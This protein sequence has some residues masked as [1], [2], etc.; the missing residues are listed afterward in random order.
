MFLDFKHRHGS[1]PRQDLDKPALLIGTKMRH[2]NEGHP[3]VRRQVAEQ[4]DIGFHTA[5]RSTDSHHRKR[6]QVFRVGFGIPRG[7]IFRIRIFRVRIY[8]IGASCF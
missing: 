4:I 8:R 3:R 1:A 6:Q 5:G 7:R 2:K